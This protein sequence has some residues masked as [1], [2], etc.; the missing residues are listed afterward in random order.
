MDA[1][2]V[3]NAG[4]S[5]VKFQLYGTTGAGGLERL[6]KGQMDGIGVRARLRAS[7]ADGKALVAVAPDGTVWVGTN[8]GE[9][10]IRV[11]P[12]S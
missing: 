11:V 7:G 3:A 4:S 1:V 5:S 12:K 8:Q 6:V 10:V 2:L 9:D